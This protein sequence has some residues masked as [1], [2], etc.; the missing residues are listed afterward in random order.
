MKTSLT[1]KYYQEILQHMDDLE[2]PEKPDEDASL[3]EKY[4]WMDDHWSWSLYC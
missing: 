4:R 3:S 1:I 2:E